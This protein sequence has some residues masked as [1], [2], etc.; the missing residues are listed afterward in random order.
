MAEIFRKS[1]IENVGGVEQLNKTIVIVSPSFWLAMLGA[2]G[3]IGMVT[4]WAF[5]GK[6]EDN[7]SAGGIFMNREGIHSGHTQKSIRYIPR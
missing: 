6:L 3:I 5:F 4:L 7:V 1:A 2:A